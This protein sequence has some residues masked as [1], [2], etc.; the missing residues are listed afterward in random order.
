MALDAGL[1]LVSLSLRDAGEEGVEVEGDVAAVGGENLGRDGGGAGGESEEAGEALVW[2]PTRFEGGAFCKSTV[3]SREGDK[4]GIWGVGARFSAASSSRTR[5]TERRRATLTP[6]S[7]SSRSRSVSQRTPSHAASPFEVS[8]ERGCD[9]W[10]EEEEPRSRY[11]LRIETRNAASELR[12]LACKGG[13]QPGAREGERGRGRTTW[14]ACFDQLSSRG[15]PGGRVARRFS[16]PNLTRGRL[17]EAGRARSLEKTASR[18][19]AS[20]SCANPETML[21]C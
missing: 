20:R 9:E 7:I 6:K 21:K 16:R 13:T 2:I 18:S 8:R 3:V 15:A 17:L 14:S 4:D 10:C 1:L 5:S 11:G 19:S 12:L